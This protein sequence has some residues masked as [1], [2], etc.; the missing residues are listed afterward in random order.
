M[1][2]HEN[3]VMRWWKTARQEVCCMASAVPALFADLGS[4]LAPVLFATDAQGASDADVG[5]CGIVGPD[6]DESL[7]RQVFEVGRK[8]GYSVTRLSGEF[9]GLR[10]PQEVIARRVPFSRLPPQLLDPADAA[11]KPIF[12]R[13]WCFADHI[14]LGESRAV[15]RLVRGIAAVPSAHRHKIISL[16]DNRATAGSFAKGR[17]PAPALNFLLRQRAAA[18]VAAQLQIMLPWVQTSAMAADGLSRLL[19]VAQTSRPA[20]RG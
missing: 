13:R 10:R 6:V 5:G 1:D 17:S 7:G 16:P 20:P 18:A 19:P 2:E 11:W 3:E 12:S 14:T 4:P 15:V 8:P 9:T